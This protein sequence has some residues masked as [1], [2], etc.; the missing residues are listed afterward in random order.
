MT[1]NSNHS[2][3]MAIAISGKTARACDC[4]V[5][6]R[7][8]WYCAADDAFLCQSCDGSVHSANPLARRHERVRLKT[9]SLKSS[10]DHLPTWH[11][12]L[13]RKP[14]TPRHG[15]NSS[16]SFTQ[17]TTANHNP[18]RVV[19]DLGI[20]ETNSFSSSHGED[21][22][23]LL[24][25]VPEY[26]PFMTE[27][28]TSSTNTPIIDVKNDHQFMIKL[29]SDLELEEFAADVETLLGKGLDDESFGIEE[30]GLLDHSPNNINNNNNNNN[31]IN[32]NI[33][34]DDNDNDDDEKEQDIVEFGKAVKEENVVI[35]GGELMKCEIEIE[36]DD[37]GFRVPFDLSFDYDFPTSCDDLEGNNHQAMMVVDA[38]DSSV[39][40]DGTKHGHEL[41]KLE[42]INDDDNNDDSKEDNKVMINKRR[43]IL[44]R[45]DYEAI[46]EAWSS[47][48]SPW[49]NGQRPEISPDDSWPHCLGGSGTGTH[50]TLYGDTQMGGNRGVG[51]GGREARVSRYREKRRT[52][53]FSK[54][55]RYEV[56]KLN[57]EKRPR[58]KGRF[59]KRS[60][61]AP[62]N[63]A[64][65]LISKRL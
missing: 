33:D 31:S 6:K 45:L 37:I 10:D 28:C 23:Q 58:M 26:D 43:K 8:R 52:R 62:T 3:N 1:S 55:I 2:N 41:C 30:L 4:C 53:L 34:D 51:D 17:N 50:N 49:M 59:V 20:E 9:A 32:I 19:P 16:K 36:S 24:F 56:R 61:F 14:R 48:G 12:G 18:T 21:E 40:D 57:A 35:G 22:E 64:F 39:V 13:T 11:R 42:G 7:A 27:F 47:H 15:K 44:L 29:P 46:S 5:R 60:S 65:P 63:T 38:V 54:K 25:R